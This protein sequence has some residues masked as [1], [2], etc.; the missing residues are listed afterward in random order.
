MSR[1]FKLQ[2]ADFK[3]KICAAGAALA[4]LFILTNG[5]FVAA[6]DQQWG[7]IKGR[8][9]WGKNIPKRKP[10]ESV[11]ANAD[12][13]HCLS[14]GPL[15]DEKWVVDAKDKGLRWTFV[16]LA[17]LD[18]KGGKSLPVHPSLQK[19]NGPVACVGSRP[20]RPR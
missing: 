19:I 7:S 10:L 18:P 20:E 12:K 14:K 16:W 2:I 8:I 17:P 13:D 3:L 5:A 9:V 1:H 11:K 6:G 4:G 15:L